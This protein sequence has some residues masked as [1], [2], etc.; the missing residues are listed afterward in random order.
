V[1]EDSTVIEAYATL[2]D[3]HRCSTDDILIDPRLRALYLELASG[4][5]DSVEEKEALHKLLYLRKRGRLPRG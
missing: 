3:A 1:I 4:P 5:H 2:H